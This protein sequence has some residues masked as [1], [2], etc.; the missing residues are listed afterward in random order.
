L[1]VIRMQNMFI[2]CIEEV[3]EEKEIDMTNANDLM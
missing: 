3:K 2:F 1:K